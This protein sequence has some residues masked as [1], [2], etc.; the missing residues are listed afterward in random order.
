LLSGV[1]INLLLLVSASR[2]LPEEPELETKEGV[3]KLGDVKVGGTAEVSTKGKGSFPLVKEPLLGELKVAIFGLGME[4]GFVLL[5]VGLFGPSFLGMGFAFVKGPWVECWDLKVG[6][7]G[8][9]S[10]RGRSPLAASLSPKLLWE[11]SRLVRLGSFFKLSSNMD[12]RLPDFTGA[13]Q[14]LRLLTLEETVP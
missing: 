6:L 10:A 12:S 2:K 14:E 1:G 9:P 4:I 13:P 5:A 3:G 8:I 7:W 11:R